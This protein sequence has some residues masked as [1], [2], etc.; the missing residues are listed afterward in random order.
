MITALSIVVNIILFTILGLKVF[1]VM[2]NS[3]FYDFKIS[4]IGLLAS[5]ILFG[6]LLFQLPAAIGYEQTST[7][8]DGADTITVTQTSNDYYGALPYIDLSNYLLYTIFG[9][10]MVEWIIY[11]I[12]MKRKRKN[13]N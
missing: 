5:I 4:I 1:N 12:P 10:S 2:K 8:I 13:E 9:F 11:A 7:I 6:L 3:Q